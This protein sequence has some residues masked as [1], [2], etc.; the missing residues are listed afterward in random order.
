MKY[1]SNRSVRL[2][3]SISDI[4]QISGL[5]SDTIIQW[6]QIFPLRPTRNRADKR[7]YRQVDLHK[8]QWIQRRIS[9]VTDT[10]DIIKELENY[11]PS[12]LKAALERPPKPSVDLEAN[13]DDSRLPPID[14]QVLTLE[15]KALIKLLGQLKST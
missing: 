6:E 7:V 2:Y 11:S 8:V 15:V 13:D 9:E 12:E 3:F 14:R 5:D 1:G 4:S 10:A